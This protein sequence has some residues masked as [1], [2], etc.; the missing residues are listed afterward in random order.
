[1]VEEL[2]CQIRRIKMSES[3]RLRR[4]EYKRNRKRWIMIQT[5]ALVV[6]VVVALGSYVVYD[7]MNRTYYIEYTESGEVDYKVYLKDNNFFEKDYI[8]KDHSYV[9]SLIK[10]MSADF[11]YE[12]NMDTSRVG[13][14]YSYGIDANVV[15]SNIDSDDP[16]LVQ[17]YELVPETK[18]TM[19][20]GSRLK[21]DQSVA[22]DYNEYNAY[23]TTFVNTYGLKRASSTLVVTMKVDVL[24]RC[25]EFE[26]N[27]AN[28]YSVSLNIPLTEENFSIFSTS[29]VPESE[30]KVLACNGAAYQGL[31]LTAAIVAAALAFV[32]LIALVIY[33]F[34]TKNDDI[35]YTNKVR[36][37]VSA[38]R[39]FIQ[40]TDREFDLEGYQVIPI[41]TF[42]EMLGIRDTIQSPIL[43]FEN[44]D[45]TKTQF[46]ISTNTRIVYTYEIKVDNYDE[47]YDEH[48]AEPSLV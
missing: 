31:F 43:M 17:T 11:S 48:S 22:I 15:V 39:S 16:I 3:E 30:S 32:L 25:D 10:D 29:S 28:S 4:Q 38:Y 34:A 6:A 45:Q 7:T 33:V 20:S 9:A 21:I 13:F 23:A 14:D 36:K 2:I 26:N 1:M 19:E 12:L 27:S 46:V 18:A 44:R 37:L 35:N 5:I 47:L 8:E 42:N 24:S 40:Q 41:K